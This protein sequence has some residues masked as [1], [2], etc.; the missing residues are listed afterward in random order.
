VKRVGLVFDE[1]YLWHDT[2]VMQP[3][4]PL[5]EPYPHWESPEAKRRFKNLL[6]ASGLS[7]SLVALEPRPATDDEILRLH[8][9]AYLA[10]LS[11]AS[12][13][14]GG[15]AGD[16]TPFGRGSLEIARL[17]TGGCILAADA[18]LD[19]RV[20]AAYA[21]VR[22]PGHHAEPASGRGFCLLGNV[23]ITALHLRAARG[24]CRIAVVDWDVHH[25]NGTETAFWRD[26]DV[27]AISLHQ[28]GLYPLGRGGVGDV[29]EGTGYGSTVN[30]P[31]P[32]GSARAAYVAACE[33]VVIPALE[34]FSPE[35]VLVAS[36]LDASAFD[37]L[38]RMQLRSVDYRALT[39]LLVAA[40]ERIC[41]GRLVCCH[42]G[43]YS[44]VYVPYCG[45]AV[46][47]GLLGI[48]PV[49]LD[50]FMEDELDALTSRAALP[51]ELAAVESARAQHAL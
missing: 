40:T 10:W 13:S 5:V 17:S 26:P 12:A 34:R 4:P 7:S 19:R 33:Q 16:G 3:G 14:A 45:A 25:G 24:V 47:E 29:G 11:E 31:L 23:A 42:E 27:L 20:D 43:G 35:I 15:D 50:P 9:P 48:E 41:A 6:D 8:E 30:V 32:A 28:D 49:V 38:G 2:G 1:R 37:P 22:P 44:A 21:L 18:V 36:G 51:H 39:D 46:V